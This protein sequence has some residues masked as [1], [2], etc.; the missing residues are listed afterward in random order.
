MQV[1]INSVIRPLE[2]IFKVWVRAFT[3]ILRLD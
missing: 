1:T 3:Y 2:L